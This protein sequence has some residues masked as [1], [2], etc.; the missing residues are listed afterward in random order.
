M[1]TNSLKS[2]SID[3]LEHIPYGIDNTA[4]FF[5]AIKI[6]KSNRKK[7]DEDVQE[8]MKIKKPELVELIAQTYLDPVKKKIL[9][10]ISDKPTTIPQVMNMCNIAPTLGYRKINS[11][12]NSGL[13]IPVSYVIIQNRKVKKYITVIENVIIHVNKNTI[14][15]KVRFNKKKQL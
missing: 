8:W 7:T 1:M 13:I 5:E 9:N 3:R 12:I 10:T 11:L 15:V 2:E 4:N 14:S 6:I